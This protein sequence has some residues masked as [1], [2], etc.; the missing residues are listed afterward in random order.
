MNQSPHVWWNFG[1][2]GVFG[3]VFLEQIGVPIPAFPALLGAGALVATGA[4][5]LPTC[6]VV[7]MSAALLADLIWYGIGRAKGVQVLHLVCRVSWKPDTCV[8]KTKGAYA[9]LGVRTLLFSKFFPG[10]SI[11]AAPLAGITQ[12]SL[13]Q[14]ILYDG[15]GAAIWALA[16]LIVG[17]YL[18]KSFLA[19][20]QQ[21][22]SM[23]PYL[24]WICG[25]LI[26]VVLIWRYVERSQYLKMLR[27]NLRH[28][29]TV[30][31]LKRRLDHGDE[32]VVV[33]VRHEVN[34]QAQPVCLPQARWIPNRM[35]VDRLSELDLDKTIIVYCDCPHDQG[36][37]DI[38]NVLRHHGAKDA[39]PLRGGLDE[40]ILKGFPTAQLAPLDPS[41]H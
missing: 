24:P 19:W 36:A 21:A 33:D 13:I 12:V 11:L 28:G 20:Q 14:F 10:L 4:L 22:W 25:T 15:T 32:L 2:A 3:C 16:P 30:D 5:S 41:P 8:S 9:R 6:V 37:V 40:W 7:A 38:V 29:I 23:V 18:Q 31:E 17:A 39:H 27:E 34:V 35:I 1:Y 26:V